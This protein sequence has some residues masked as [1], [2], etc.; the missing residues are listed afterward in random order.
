LDLALRGTR[1]NP[2]YHP[3]AEAA[4]EAFELYEA[5]EAVA[6]YSS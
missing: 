6:W 2:E 5:P 1:R 3:Q 4:K